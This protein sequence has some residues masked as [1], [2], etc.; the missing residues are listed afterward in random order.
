MHVCVQTDRQ[1]E[2]EWI[3]MPNDLLNVPSL[4]QMSDRIQLNIVYP[5]NMQSVHAVLKCITEHV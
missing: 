5:L 4:C 3:R 2:N 1:R